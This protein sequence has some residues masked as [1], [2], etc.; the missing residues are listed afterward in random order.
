MRISK[1]GITLIRLTEDDL[2]LLRTKRNSAEVNAYMEY[3]EYITQEMQTA[4]Y[5]TINNSN[6]FYYIIEYKSE[7]IGLVNDKNIDW[8][9]KISEG[10]LFIWDARYVNSIVPLLVSYLV[11]EI[12]FYV[13]G[14]DKSFIKVLRSN[15][16]AV[17]FNSSLG[18]TILDDEADVDYLLMMLTRKQFEQKANKL[19]KVISHLP[20]NERILLSFDKH[21]DLNGTRTSVEKILTYA[22]PLVLAEKVEV[23]YL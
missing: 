20:S 11:I 10:G 13:L 9:H 2:E 5:S 18:F 17:D 22:H 12:A 6:N 21:D 1:Y 19:K 14:W 4:W 8:E 16:R 15:K 7:K 23:V 3:R